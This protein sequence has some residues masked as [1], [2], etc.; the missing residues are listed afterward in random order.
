MI[1]GHP[2]TE[3]EK[4]YKSVT[5]SHTPNLQLPHEQFHLYISSYYKRNSYIIPII[6]CKYINMLKSVHNTQHPFRNKIF[7]FSS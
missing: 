3:G 4:G 7:F 6:R 1:V 2:L 5:N